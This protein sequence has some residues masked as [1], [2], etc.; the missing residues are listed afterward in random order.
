MY[1]KPENLV[2]AE[3][4]S[5]LLQNINYKYTIIIR[6]IIILC[7]TS[8]KYILIVNCYL[9]FQSITIKNLTVQNVNTNVM[10]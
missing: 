7:F 3:L 8:L 10:E 2:T 6:K 5:R 4:D 9:I 1:R